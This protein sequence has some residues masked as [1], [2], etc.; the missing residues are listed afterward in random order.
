[1]DFRFDEVQRDLR[2]LAGR[3]VEQETTTDR[4]RELEAG[5]E[6]VDRA[7]WDELAKAN[8]L[9]LAI[10]EAYGG[11]GLSVLEAALVLE[12]IGRNVAPVP[13]LATVVMGA[14]PIAAF[15]D[16]AL[17][18][19]LLPKV[20]EG[21]VFLTAAVQEPANLDHTAPVTRAIEDGEGGWRLSGIKVAVPWALLADE[22]LVTADAGLFIVARD[23]PGLTVERSEATHREPQ[24]YVILEDVRAARVG[25]PEATRFLYEHALAGICATAVGML[26]GALRVTAAYIS[27]REQFGKPLAAFQGATM[28]IADAYIDAEAVAATTWS[29]VWRLADGRPAADAL[30]MAKFWVADGGQRAVH[31][32]QHLHGGMGVDVDYPIHRYFLWAKELELTLGGAT[33]QL[34]DL[35]ASLVGAPR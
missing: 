24:G 33:P 26:E 13:F 29:A 12:A 11:S 4:L 35:G 21:E 9:G 25:G 1:M 28:R 8:L 23:A 3:I 16:D 10:P 19:R 17:K 30:A 20:A 31:A 32:A 34:L 2:A 15:G 7:L 27:E 22:I 18:S 14:M 6:R 5:T